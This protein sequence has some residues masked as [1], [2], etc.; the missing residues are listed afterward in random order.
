MFLLRRVLWRRGQSPWSSGGAPP[1]A[2]VVTLAEGAV[3]EGERFARRS[4]AGR[5]REDGCAVRPRG[6]NQPTTVVRHGEDL[7]D[8]LVLFTVSQGHVERVPDEDL[9]G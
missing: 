7:G 2:A 6:S 8:G 9:P 4:V 3:E 1:A 5:H